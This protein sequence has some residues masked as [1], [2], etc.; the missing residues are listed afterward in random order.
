MS[1]LPYRWWRDPEVWAFVFMVLVIS[2]LAIAI[3]AV[4]WSRI[5]P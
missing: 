1:G 5:A 4:A 2:G 3:F